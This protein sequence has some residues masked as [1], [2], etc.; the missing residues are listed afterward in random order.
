MNENVD[1]SVIVATHRREREL[2]RALNSLTK[3]NFNSFEVVIVDDNAED[4]WNKKVEKV[5]LNFKNEF[6]KE[7]VKYIQN[8]PNLGSAK[9]RNKGIEAAD[10]KYITFLDDDDIYFPE[11]IKNQYDFMEENGLDYSVTDL[12]LYF[13]NEKLFERKTRTFIKKTDSES[14]LKYHFMYHIT[15]TDTM[16]FKKEYLL[17]IG[18]FAPIDVGDEFYLMHR[19]IS[20]NGKFGYLE[21]CDVKAYVHAGE[22]GL[23]S[24]KQ[25]IDGEN[26]LFEFK[27]ENY[28]L[29]D[30]KTIRYI[31]MRHNAVL[32]FAYLRMKNY[33]KFFEYAIK[34]FLVDPVLLCKM[35]FGR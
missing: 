7:K 31:T 5:V 29:F 22:G 15:G 11:K 30:K 35:V 28:C 24:G 9:T 20:Q 26:A 1:V 17:N 4:E 12:D 27:K 23:S 19:A 25:K 10:G 14:L 16:M 13:D 33:F 6:S 2:K 34:S 18:C 8:N 32:A 21:C 3:Q